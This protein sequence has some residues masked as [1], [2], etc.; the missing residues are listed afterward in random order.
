M[1]EKEIDGASL[2]FKRANTKLEEERK[3]KKEKKIRRGDK[4]GK[5]KKKMVDGAKPKTCLVHTLSH[6]IGD[7]KTF[8]TRL[9]KSWF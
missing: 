7:I 2:S 4:E 9:L 6:P 3:N 5:G 1:N 8:Q